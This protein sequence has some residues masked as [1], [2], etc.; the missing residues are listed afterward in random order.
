[1]NPLSSCS[2]KGQKSKREVE[3]PVS[4]KYY[5][6]SAKVCSRGCSKEPYLITVKGAV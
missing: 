1:M 3:I 6:S 5:Y 4:R 2:N